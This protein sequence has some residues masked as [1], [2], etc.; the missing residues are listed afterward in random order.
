MNKEYHWN[1][2]DQ[3]KTIGTQGSENGI[4]IRDEE[5][6]FGARITLEENSSIAPFS[7]TVGIYGLMVHT[8]FYDTIENATIGFEKLKAKVE[9]I[10]EHYSI[11]K[12]KRDSKW[13]EK[14]NELMEL[15]TK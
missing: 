13:N 10:I 14:L 15:L 12:N 6:S 2:F 4:I 7:I 5:N 3:K 9:N 11:D 8:D 1:P